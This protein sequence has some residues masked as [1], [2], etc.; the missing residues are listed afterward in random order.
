L[1]LVR[2]AVGQVSVQGLAPAAWRE[3]DAASPWPLR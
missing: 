1:R 3:I 2:A